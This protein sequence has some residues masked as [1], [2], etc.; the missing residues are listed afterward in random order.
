MS[1]SQRRVY[2]QV[3]AIVPQMWSTNMIASRIFDQS[4]LHYRKNKDVPLIR[5]VKREKVVLQSELSIMA[6]IEFHERKVKRI[7]KGVAKIV[8]VSAPYMCC[9]TCDVV[10]KSRPN[11]IRPKCCDAQL[12]HVVDIFCTKHCGKTFNNHRNHCLHELSCTGAMSMQSV[13]S[14]MQILYC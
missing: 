10:I 1:Q 9:V 2:D 8:T 14:V 11:F 12:P 3:I 13:V 7:E 6:H 4:H 5:I